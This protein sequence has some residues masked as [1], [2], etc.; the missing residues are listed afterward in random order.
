MKETYQID[1][2]GAQ[3]GDH[4]TNNSRS[5]DIKQPICAPSQSLQDLNVCLEQ[6]IL[7]GKLNLGY[8]RILF[9]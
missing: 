4:L 3:I 5:N 2:E 9:I 1:Q 6:E 7:L 8:Y